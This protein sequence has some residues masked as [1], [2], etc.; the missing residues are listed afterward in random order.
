MLL[1][2]IMLA[3]GILCATTTAIAT[4]TDAEI[5]KKSISTFMTENDIPGV[6]VEI[7]KDGKAQSY[8]FGYANKAKKTPITEKTI[9]EVGSITKLMTAIL[10]A[11]QIDAAKT[12][13]DRSITDY[14]PNL[15]A[16]FE[17]ITLENL[18]T[19]TSGLPSF[20][21]EDVKT[22]TALNTYLAQI[23]PEY[24]ADEE[25]IYSNIGV[26]LL[27]L[28]LENMTHQKIEVLYQRQIFSPL[29]M[30]TAFINVPAKFKKEIATGYGKSGDEVPATPVGVLPASASLKISAQSMR[31]FLAASIGLPGTESLLYPMRASQ[32]SYFRLGDRK[33]GLIWQVNSL[34]ANKIKHLLD[35]PSLKNVLGPIPVEEMY[36][37]AKF[38]ADTLIDKT[39]ASDGFRSYI[40]VLP[41]KKSGIVIL[42]NRQVLNNAIVKAGREIL[43]QL[44]QIPMT[45]DLEDEDD[46]EQI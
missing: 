38:N 1:K 3:L 26:G 37:V 18:A 41:N 34:E 13:Y 27:G 33:Q 35:T 2:K 43:L 32:A 4:Q 25:W 12:E 14:L 28:A 46:D 45:D 8:Y 11:Q 24:A 39:G 9:F 6:A 22:A 16:D 20:L 5:V 21:P 23:K 17:D 36:D 30:K 29:H 40:A 15:S 10:L 31:Q 19:H 44:A 42:A 7:Y